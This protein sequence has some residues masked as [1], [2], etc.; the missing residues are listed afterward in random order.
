MK[1]LL[2]FLQNC[3][4]RHSTRFKRDVGFKYAGFHAYVRSVR[5]RHSHHRHLCTHRK[6]LLQFFYIC[7]VGFIFS[8]RCNRRVGTERLHPRYGSVLIARVQVE[9]GRAG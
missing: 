8:L 7:Y 1:I 5:T 3:V 4:Q 2:V 6:A 9:Y